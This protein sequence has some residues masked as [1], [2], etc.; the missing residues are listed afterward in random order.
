LIRAF[1]DKKE[2]YDKFEML[3]DELQQP[4]SATAKF[5]SQA[6]FYEEGKDVGF[7]S[8]KNICL[9]ALI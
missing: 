8:L 9:W 5:L 1:S 6:P 4:E 7:V 3:V 2:D